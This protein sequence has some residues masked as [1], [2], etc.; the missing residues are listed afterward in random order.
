VY[1]GQFGTLG[2]I[3]RAIARTRRPIGRR[4]V[5]Y[6]AVV[7]GLKWYS[8]WAATGYGGQLLRRPNFLCKIFSQK[9]VKNFHKNFVKIFHARACKIFTTRWS[10]LAHIFSA[11]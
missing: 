6:F 10:V 11:C 9:I 4:L 8:D 2:L 1:S 5:V 3:E 7:A